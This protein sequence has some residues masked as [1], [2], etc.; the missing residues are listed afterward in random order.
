M[1]PIENA[2]SIITE[3]KPIIA[4]LASNPEVINFKNNG[5][6]MMEIAEE[7]VSMA[8]CIA[9]TAGHAGTVGAVH[10]VGARR[11]PTQM[12]NKNNI[13]NHRTF[14]FFIRIFFF[15]L[16]PCGLIIGKHCKHVE[17]IENIGDML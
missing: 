7:L 1:T 4:A 12:N 10:T 13:G 14:V 17:H 6:S 5:Q 16:E 15:F 8:Q 2:H 3:M 11:W 9:I